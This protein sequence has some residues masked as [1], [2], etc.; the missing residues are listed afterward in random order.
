MAEWECPNLKK[1]L[2]T[3]CEIK[4]I[5]NLNFPSLECIDLSK[6][7]INDISPMADWKCPNCKIINFSR[8]RI[9]KIEKID[10]PSVEII[11]LSGNYLR[12]ASFLSRSTSLIKLKIL[13]LWDCLV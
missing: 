7:E 12:D 6:N 9:A 3:G 8:C 2:L 13:N 5:G 11:N 4:E 1:V 10:L